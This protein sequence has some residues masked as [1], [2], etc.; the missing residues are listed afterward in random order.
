VGGSGKRFGGQRSGFQCDDFVKLKQGAKIGGECD[1]RGRWGSSFTRRRVARRRDGVC[2]RC[3][4]MA[5]CS[6]PEEG[7]DWNWDERAT[8]PGGPDHCWAGEDVKIMID[9]ND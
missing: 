9:R 2:Q 8:W 4:G 6:K 5:M 1:T 7:D 3:L